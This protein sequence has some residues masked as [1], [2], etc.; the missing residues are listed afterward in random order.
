[1]RTMFPDYYRPKAQEFALKFRECAFCFDTNVLLNLYRYTPESRESLLQALKKVKDRV[2]LPNRVAFEYQRRRTDILLGQ[3]G[4]VGKIEGAIDAA[5]KK[6]DELARS[7][8]LF[9]VDALIAPYRQDLEGIKAKLQEKKEPPPDLMDGDPIFDALTELFDGKV[10]AP[11]T[12]EQEDEIFKKGKERY[13]AKVPP[14]FKDK[15]QDPNDTDQYGDLLIW[16]QL[17]DYAKTE[18]RPIIFVTDDTKED[19]WHIVREQTLGPRLELKSEYRVQT[20]GKWFFL[21]STEQFFKHANEYLAAEVPTKAIQEAEEIKKQDA[22]ERKHRPTGEDIH[23][24]LEALRRGDERALAIANEVVRARP[25]PAPSILSP[26]LADAARQAR[27]AETVYQSSGL[28]ALAEQAR[29]RQAAIDA[30]LGPVLEQVRRQQA[31]LDSAFGPMREEMRRQQA[32]VDAVMGPVREQL[33]RQQAVV[34]AVTRPM[35]EVQAQLDQ[36][37]RPF[38]EIQASLG[39]ITGPFRSHPIP[40]EDRGVVDPEEAG[41]AEERG[42]AGSEPEADRP[43]GDSKSPEPEN[44]PKE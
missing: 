40:R 39:S 14:G 31:I 26:L 27:I 2:W 16:F 7:S 33:R 35:R 21:Y 18:A 29:Q 24:A 34:D 41:E 3:I 10:G 22:E 23:E 37:M 6:I 13:D 9:A 19:W 8:H 5:I 32:A 43:G 30:A 20:G 17:I 1:M 38:R 44:K 42:E 15:S 4:L 36:A 12:K 28:S 11:Y 25:S